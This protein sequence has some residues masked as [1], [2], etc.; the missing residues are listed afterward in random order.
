MTL[1]SFTALLFLS[2]LSPALAATDELASCETQYAIQ[3]GTMDTAKCFYETGRDLD[4]KEEA[5][6]RLRALS[7]THPDDPW[8]VFYSGHLDTAHSEEIYR[9]AASGF[10]KKN[11]R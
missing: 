7:K 3:P 9:K 2:L 6:R 10:Q 1:K 4:Q 5:L 11:D 8:L